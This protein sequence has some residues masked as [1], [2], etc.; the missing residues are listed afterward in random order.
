[1]VNEAGTRYVVD[2]HV[3]PAGSIHLVI[4]LFLAALAGL[5]GPAVL[6]RIRLSNLTAVGIAWVGVAVFEGIIRQCWMS[7][8]AGEPYAEWS[9][10]DLANKA[11]R[12]LPYLAAGTWMRWA[13]PSPDPWR[14]AIPGG[15]LPALAALRGYVVFVTTSLSDAVLTYT[16]WCFQPLVW[17]ASGAW[18]CGV[19]CEVQSRSAIVRQAGL[20]VIA[21]L[22]AVAL[23]IAAAN[24]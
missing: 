17:A 15:I 20:I 16:S 4:A 18:G 19:L 2:L 11:E 14:A 24:R 1:M 6:R 9:V 23:G 8:Y 3:T 5:M 21:A 7:L 12:I 10:P 22:A 13:V